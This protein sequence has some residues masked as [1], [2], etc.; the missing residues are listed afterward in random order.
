M[1]LSTI[2]PSAIT[3]EIKHPQTGEDIGVSVT[4]V[5]LESEQ[6]KGE[7]RRL[8]DRR[9]KAESRNKHLKAEEMEEAAVDILYSC[10]T[11]WNWR[12]VEDS[13]GNMQ[14]APTFE[15]EVPDFNRRN[16]KRV[17][18]ALPWF[19]AQVDDIVEEARDFYEKSKAK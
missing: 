17:F 11:D 5:Q 10:M 6:T 18:K 19:Q 15:G 12:A 14:D 8:M 16:V 2:K 1:E 3:R 4:V 13:K 7:R 9:A